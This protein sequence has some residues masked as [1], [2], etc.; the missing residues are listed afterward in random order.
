MKY[1]L[2]NKKGIL[3]TNEEYDEIHSSI[4]GYCMAVKDGLDYLISSK[5]GSIYNCNSFTFGKKQSE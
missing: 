5:D 1:T 3:I 2:I 4:N